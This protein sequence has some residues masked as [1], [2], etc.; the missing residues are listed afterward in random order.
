VNV[1]NA[2]ANSLRYEP[3]SIVEID[4]APTDCTKLPIDRSGDFGASP[5]WGSSKASNALANTK[6]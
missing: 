1:L 3:T 4:F 5:F 6:I 2:G